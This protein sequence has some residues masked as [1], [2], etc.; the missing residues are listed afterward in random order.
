MLITISSSYW[1]WSLPS[2]L[3]LGLLQ[4]FVWISHHYIRA[5]YVLYKPIKFRIRWEIR[6]KNFKKLISE[7]FD[8]LPPTE[9]PSLFL[10][11]CK[12]TAEYFHCQ[13]YN[14]I[15]YLTSLIINTKIRENIGLNN[16]LNVVIQSNRTDIWRIL[17]SSVEKPR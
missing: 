2:C 12:T 17:F 4:K 11:F 5:D 8:C 16:E 15:F 10:I 3:Q 1:G 13:L 9:T 7:T 6:I 14:Q